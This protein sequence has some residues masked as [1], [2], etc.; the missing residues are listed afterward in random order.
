[1][2]LIKNA[3][4]LANYTWFRSKSNLHCN[5]YI[6]E[7]TPK[8]QL[9]SDN[10]FYLA[11]CRIMGVIFNDFIQTYWFCLISHAHGIIM[12]T[13]LQFPLFLITHSPTINTISTPYFYSPFFR[14]HLFYQPKYGPQYLAFYSY[15][16]FFSQMEYYFIFY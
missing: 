11:S 12:H 14:P 9:R 4:K 3:P 8:C 6:L 13:T 5:I 2:R 1:M 15:A 7:M 10:N 16:F